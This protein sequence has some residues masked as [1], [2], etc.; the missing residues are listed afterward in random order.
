MFS[1]FN[2]AIAYSKSFLASSIFSF[3]TEN[4]Y[5]LHEGKV[6]LLIKSSE[7]T[8]AFGSSIGISRSG[9]HAI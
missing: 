3:L 6:I 2:G 7:P 1:V 8:E 5:K 9:F 4:E